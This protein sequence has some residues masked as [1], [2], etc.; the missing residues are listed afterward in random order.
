MPTLYDLIEYT[1]P[2]DIAVTKD[3]YAKVYMPANATEWTTLLSG[4]GLNNPSSYW[5]A[6]NAIGASL[7]DSGTGG[8][9][10]TI[11]GSPTLGAAAPG[12]QATGI[13]CTDGSNTQYAMCTVPGVTTSSVLLLQVFGVNTHPAAMRALNNIGGNEF[14]GAEVTAG[15]SG[16]KVR[17]RCSGNTS[18]GVVNYSSIM[19]VLTKHDITN[20]ELA[21]YTRGEQVKPTWTGVTASTDLFVL[22]DTVQAS[23]ATLVYAALWTGADAE[24]TDAQVQMLIDFV[25]GDS[26]TLSKM[27]AGSFAQ[28]LVVAIEGCQY[29]LSDAPEASVIQAWAGS[30]WTQCLPG[31]F[32][33]LKNMHTLQ[34]WQPFTG[35]GSCTVRVVDTDGS[36]TFGIL[37][38]RRL[39]GAESELT[40]TVDRNDTT[41]P[42]ASS[43]D[44]ASSGTAY[45]GTEAVGYTGVTATSLTGAT[46]G[47]WSPFGCAPSG[48]GGNR[49]AGHHRVGPDSYQVLTKPLVTQL[50]RVWLGKRVGVWLHTWSE[51]EQSLNSRDEAQL[52]Y[53]GRIAGIADDPNDGATVIDVSPVHD[54]IANG[55]IGRD[56]PTAK[57]AEGLNIV[58]GRMFLFQD[59]MYTGSL[60][61]SDP[62]T[63]VASGATGTNEMNAGRYTLGE[64]CEKLNAWLAGEKAAARIYGYYRWASPVT[65]NVGL[66]TKC[67]W[68]IGDSGNE[69]VAWGIDMPGEVMAFLGLRSNEP[70]YSGQVQKFSVSGYSNQNKIAEGESVP[71]TNLVFK[72]SGPGRLTQDASQTITYLLEDQRGTFVNQYSCL[73]A[74]IK[75][76]CDSSLTWG[77]FLLNENTLIVGSYST[78]VL[79]NC[80]LAP[81]QITADK[82]KESASYIGRRADEP[83]GGDITIRQILIL[84]SSLSTLLSTLIYG[85]GTAGY[86]H[87]TFDALGYGF[88][89]GIPGELLG[90]S[91]DNS[92]TNLPQS[93]APVAVVIDEPTKFSEL[94]S[95]DLIIRRGLLRWKDESFEFAQWK[96]PMASNAVAALTEDNKAAPSGHL[97]NHR[98]ATLE[99]AEHARPVVKVD[100][101]RDFAVGR[102]GQYLKSLQL[103]DATAVDDAGGDVKAFTIKARNAYH[104]FQGTGAAVEAL[105]P[106]FLA[107]MPAVA[108]PGRILTRS[109]DSRLFES[110]AVGDVVTVSDKFARDPISGER[111]IGSRPAVVTRISYD[112]GGPS[113]NGTVRQMGGEVEL[114]FLDLH[115]SEIYAPAAQVDDTATNGGYNAGTKVLTCYEHKYSHTVTITVNW[116]RISRSFH[117]EEDA[118]ATWFEVGDE[119]NVIEMDPADPANPLT[120]SDTVASQTGDTLLGLTTGLAGWDSSKKYRIVPQKY[121]EVALSQRDYSYQA[122]S[123]DRMVEDLVP[124]FHYAGSSDETKFIENTGDEPAELIPEMAYGDG[125]PQDPGYDRALIHSLNGAVDYKTAHQAPQLWWQRCRASADGAADPD[126]VVLFMGPI[127]LGLDTHSAVL[128]RSLTVAPF[129]GSGGLPAGG[130]QSRVRVTL[131]R[132]KP[133]M[134]TAQSPYELGIVPRYGN[135]HFTG[136]FS[137]TAEWST[138]STT[139]QTGADK[140]VSIS[141]KDLTWGYAWLI[142]EGVNDAYCWGLAKCIEGPRSLTTL[143]N[144]LLNDIE[145]D[146]T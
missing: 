99:T 120:W 135:P 29:L 117:V 65:S 107:F 34:P 10:V 84:E 116:G 46:R 136:E 94:F 23:D 15:T 85:T 78:G 104:D 49:F 100:Y 39:A 119:V 110:I 24:L 11:A 17:G 41:I 53:A 5:I 81:F 141:V 83:E 44:F 114:M 74:V 109:I 12:F 28:K 25:Y 22:G 92:L 122:D 98:V 9:T 35:G 6:A 97:E 128:T 55:V 42:I 54:E 112:L 57:V 48:S 4:T 87:S 113:S 129:F 101:A 16:L 76:S 60:Q 125:R 96:T 102:D 139:L 64:L 142:I 56:F 66:R 108:R 90:G 75:A 80:W 86:N 118:D 146:L 91:F 133:Q 88:G 38:N 71:F 77:V 8:R 134:Q 70:A 121:S 145:Y 124:F 18:D 130:Y 62:L 43:Q 143:G 2:G 30:D 32:V 59:N 51:Q 95:A 37:V 126:W 45:I 73:P 50:P 63:V 21:V 33:E 138:T 1:V 14:Q 72:P 69:P 26:T 103:E 123:T 115:R 20:S 93:N 137:Q 19:V 140:T 7:A 58:A 106:E 13:K 127:F 47:K 111:E 132:M 61:T 36:D 27:Q 31:L 68:I 89:L 3:A 82:D 67:Y 79:S 40:E 131:A 105:I 144:A 52:L